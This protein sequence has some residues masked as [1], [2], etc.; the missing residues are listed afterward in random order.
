MFV[1]QPKAGELSEISE[2]IDSEKSTVV[3]ET[4]LPLSDTT[5]AQELSQTGH[6]REKIVLKV[7]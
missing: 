2:L 3:V 7:A 5:R 6:A 4:V 1:R